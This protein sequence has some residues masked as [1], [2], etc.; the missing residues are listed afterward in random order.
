MTERTVNARQLEVLKWIVDGCP[1]GVMTGT[2]HKTTAVALQGRRLVKVSKKG[3]VW[4]AEPTDA[5]RQFLATGAYPAGHW[6]ASRESPARLIPT[7]AAKPAKPSTQPKVTGLRPVDQ[8]IADLIKAGGEVT[9]EVDNNRQ[10]YWEG[11]ASS[12]TRYNKVP[13]GKLLKVTRGKAWSERIIRLEDPP[14][15]MTAVLDPIHVS[16]QLR[17]PHPVVKAIRGDR[18]RLTIRRDV[19]VRALRILDALAKS[20]QARDYEVTAPKAESGYRH[21]KGYL[22]VTINGHP[23]VVDIEELKDRVPHEP[24]AHELREKERYS[25]TRIPD[26]DHVPSGRL[27]IR[28]LRESA[29]RQDAFSDTK[30]I[31]LENR[32]PV[33][34]QELELRAA[35][36]EE[37]TQRL[38]RERQER[39]RQ[40]EQ[41]RDEA[42]VQARRL[43]RARVLSRQVELWRQAEEVDSYLAVVTEKV[44]RLPDGSEKRAATEWLAWIRDYR[45]QLDPTDQ[46]LSMPTDPE[47]T[48]E[49]LKPF[50]RGL[51]PYGPGW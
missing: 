22:N 42:I 45:S 13:S 28:L 35:A 29:V 36:A 7:A 17:N 8:M 26:Y 2:T 50:M 9:V 19:R 6:S 4:R 11:L 48:G 5:G 33:V 44:E 1:E 25:W 12:A 15:W 40:W 21:A 10:G 51:S 31:N 39:Q 32:L 38:E 23:N 20:A 47:F 49:V 41:V 27:Q 16:E 37:R 43:H 30:T 3:G 34:M 46:S 18:E 24:T 14:E